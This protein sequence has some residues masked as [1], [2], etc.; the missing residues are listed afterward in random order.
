MKLQQAQQQTWRIWHIE[1]G[2]PW[3]YT[4]VNQ[5]SKKLRD[6]V[7]MLNH[8]NIDRKNTNIS[9]LHHLRHVDILCYSYV[10]LMFYLGPLYC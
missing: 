8:P 10:L 4:E 5:G 7:H 1:N 6:Y 3:T 9:L 2:C